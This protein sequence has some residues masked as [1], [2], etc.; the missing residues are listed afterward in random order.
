MGRKIDGA[1]SDGI[2]LAPHQAEAAVGVANEANFAQR[3]ESPMFVMQSLVRP[4]SSHPASA[5]V[6][7]RAGLQEG[8]Q[9]PQPDLLA[10]QAGESKLLA[11]TRGGGTSP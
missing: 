3:G 6:L 7:F 5:V 8:Q 9:I 11:R 2:S 10:R 4:R 1:G